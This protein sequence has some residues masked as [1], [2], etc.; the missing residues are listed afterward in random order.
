[1]VQAAAKP[2]RTASVPLSCNSP[3]KSSHPSSSS[4][5]PSCSPSSSSSPAAAASVSSSSSFPSPSPTVA[6][7]S[8]KSLLESH[9][10]VRSA[11]D[12][13]LLFPIG[14]FGPLPLTFC[15]T[16]QYPGVTPTSPP[17][18]IGRVNCGLC[19][20][21][22]TNSPA[23]M[24][25]RQSLSAAANRT[26]SA[27]PSSRVATM[28]PCVLDSLT[29]R[30][31]SLDATSSRASSEASTPPPLT[32]L[33]TSVLSTASEPSLMAGHSVR[34]TPTASSISRVS[35]PTVPSRAYARTCATSANS[36]AAS[37]IRN[38]QTVSSPAG[39]RR[40]SR[41]QKM[42]TASHTNLLMLPSSSAAAVGE[43][44][45]S[46]VDAGTRARRGM[47]DTESL[48]RSAREG[49]ARWAPERHAAGMRSALIMGV[50]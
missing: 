19:A 45:G 35:S 30:A 6:A 31:A 42:V 43:S 32:K 46:A 40:L 11:A 9:S 12:A 22:A 14:P 4:S 27:M 39:G 7:G 1:M 49:P 47:R 23:T 29:A 26:H 25:T 10:S 3:P 37:T 20:A 38:A 28:T 33:M 36:N 16:R 48:G 21:L 8:S 44:L 50:A 2:P 18:V 41:S 13:S 34:V 17:S 5:S 15:S 24:A